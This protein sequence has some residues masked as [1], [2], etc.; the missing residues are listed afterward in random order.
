[1]DPQITVYNLHYVMDCFPTLSDKFT[2]EDC[3]VR[4]QFEMGLMGLEVVNGQNVSFKH[5]ST[6]DNLSSL[7]DIAKQFSQSDGTATVGSVVSCFL[8][9][10]CP[11]IL[12]C[13]LPSTSSSSSS[14]SSKQTLLQPEHVSIYILGVQFNAD[15]SSVKKNIFK[16]EQYLNKEFSIYYPVVFDDCDMSITLQLVLDLNI[17]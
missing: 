12:P 2:L 4:Y 17:I 1:M 7:N 13:R 5:Y 11:D 3:S 8:T 15:L 14:S 9:H 6:E 16:S 10:T